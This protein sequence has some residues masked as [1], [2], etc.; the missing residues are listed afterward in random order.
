MV[1]EVEGTNEFVGWYRS[2]V[3]AEVDAVNAVVEM[4]AEDGP[5]LGCPH[6]DTLQNS[7]L[8]NLKELRPP[9]AGKYLRILFVFDPRRNAILLLGGN[10][11]G[12]WTNWYKTSIPEAEQLYEI[13][14]QELVDEGLL[15]EEGT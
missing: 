13:H 7:Q 5:N 10:K 8:S 6:V 15:D 4:L 9:G 3:E 1:W 2:L 14:L 12:N 11:E